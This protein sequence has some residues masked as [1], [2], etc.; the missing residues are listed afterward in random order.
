MSTNN[1]VSLAELR[2]EAE[3]LVHQYNDAYQQGQFTE[4]SRLEEKYSDKVNE[5]TSVTRN[6]FFKHCEESGTPMI[7]AVAELTYPTIAVKEDKVGTDKIPVRSVVDASK[8]VDLAKLHKYCSS[9][10]GANKGWIGIAEKMNYLLTLKVCDELGINPREVIKNYDMS[11]A[12]RAFNFGKNPTS[13]TSLLKSLQIVI[14]AMLGEE[15]KATSHD[16][17]YLLNVYCKAGRKA[18][19]VNCAKHAHFRRYLSYICHNI[20]TG[21]GYQMGDYARKKGNDDSVSTAA[22]E[23]PTPTSEQPEAEAS[24]K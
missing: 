18:L 20:V 14:S 23:Q 11:E 13:N 17:K 5:Y 19:S 16:V 4:A 2:A 15:Y 9:G 22:P 1:N 6:A 10:I 24:T 7:T 3:E 21:D 8:E 12:A